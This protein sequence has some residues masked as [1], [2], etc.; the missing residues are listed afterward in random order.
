MI[1][2]MIWALE[3][4][5]EAQTERL[6]K[7]FNK[8]LEDLTN[9]QNKMVR[10]ISQMKNTLEG[11]NSRIM[12]A[13]EWIS[14]VE[15]RVVEITVIRKKIKKNENNWES[16][17]PLGQHQMHQCL[18]HR[19][20]RRRRERARE[21]FKEI[22]V[23]TFPSM[24]KETLTQVEEAQGIPH[25]INPRSTARHTLIKLTKVKYREKIL[26]ATRENQQITYKG[27]L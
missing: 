2:K 8:K 25:R 15:D 16:K 6:Q 9:K 27:T 17:R 11:I 5:M 13:E 23:K 26:K 21:I 24:G 22:I 3:E 10:T 1:V 20:P 19:G 4:K 7:M 12:E 18:Y 14:D